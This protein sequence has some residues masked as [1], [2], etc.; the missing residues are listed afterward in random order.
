M[1][2]DTVLFHLSQDSLSNSYVRFSDNFRRNV[3]S[4]SNNF[5]RITN[6]MYR[7]GKKYSAK[8]IHND[9]LILT[10]QHLISKDTF[11]LW[12]RDLNSYYTRNNKTILIRKSVYDLFK[13]KLQILRFETDIGLTTDTIRDDYS[14][15]EFP[16]YLV[17][18]IDTHEVKKFSIDS[19]KKVWKVY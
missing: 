10:L 2:G 18:E 5:L 12:I 1:I 19:L 16:F 14:E 6:A 3:Y 7:K 11:S 8:L 17:K 4:S 9:T 13:K 15:K